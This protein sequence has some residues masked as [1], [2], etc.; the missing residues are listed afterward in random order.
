M[1]DVSELVAEAARKARRGDL[2]L[3]AQSLIGQLETRLGTELRTSDMV[4]TASITTDADG[5]GALPS[6]YLETITLTYGTDKRQLSRLSR[7]MVHYG[8][9]G[10]FVEGATFV[11]SQTGTAHTLTYYEAIP[12]LWAAGTNWLFARRP[13]AYLWGLILES[14]EDEGNLDEAI[15]AKVLFDAELSALRRNDRRERWADTVALPRTQI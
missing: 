10:Y 6:D 11:S 9:E 12:G 13:R 4:E 15:K 1:Q 3:Y 5:V 8:V 14:F 7:Y 2:P